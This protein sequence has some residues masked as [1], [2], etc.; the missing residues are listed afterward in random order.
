MFRRG[1]QSSLG[2]VSRWR[3]WG[4]FS[5]R[6]QDGLQDGFGGWR[7]VVVQFLFWRN[8]ADWQQQSIYARGNLAELL[9]LVMSVPVTDR[10]IQKDA[11]MHS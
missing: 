11:D 1:E 3:C 6:G 10:T 7:N 2:G 9:T 5:Y 4:W 8:P